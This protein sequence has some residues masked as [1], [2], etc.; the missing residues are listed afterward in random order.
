MMVIR[1]SDITYIK[2]IF[3]ILPYLS[4]V[5]KSIVTAEGGS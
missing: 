4:F 2:Y 5:V 3:F 1:I